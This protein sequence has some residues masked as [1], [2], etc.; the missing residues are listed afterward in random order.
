MQ[1]AF[2]PASARWRPFAGLAGGSQVLLTDTS[3][4]V[5][6]ADKPH[7]PFVPSAN[8]RAH[9]GVR[10]TIVPRVQL[11]AEIEATRDWLLHSSR[12]PDYQQQRRQ[13]AVVPHVAGRALRVLKRARRARILRI[14]SKSRAHC[15]TR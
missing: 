3:G 8:L 13:H 12:E 7:A 11:L 4:T 2:A 10:V 14:L 1:Y 15:D 9:A 5:A 6:E